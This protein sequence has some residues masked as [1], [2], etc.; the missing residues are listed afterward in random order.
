MRRHLRFASTLEVHRSLPYGI[1]AIAVAVSA[2]CPRAVLAVQTPYN[3]TPAAVVANDGVLW[4]NQF[5]AAL[6]SDQT[7]YG[8][9]PKIIWVG[10]FC[11]SGG[12]VNNLLANPS[13]VYAAA[14]ANWDETSVSNPSDN[15]DIAP[16]GQT[17]MTSSITKTL[18]NSFTDGSA[19]VNAFQT[20]QQ[21]AVGNA[22]MGNLGYNNG[23]QAIIFSAGGGTNAQDQTSFWTDVSTAHNALTGNS[24]SPWPAN[25]IRTLWDQGET[26]PGA[27]NGNTGAGYVNGGSTIANLE[28]EITAAYANASF[29]SNNKLFIYMNDHG[30]NTDVVKSRVT[31]NGDGTYR[32]SY[33]VNVANYMPGGNDPYGVWQLAITTHNLT[34]ADI[35]RFNAGNLPGVWNL[36][37]IN[38]GNTI[39]VAASTPNANGEWLVGGTNYDFSYDSPD[40]PSEQ[41][42]S[43]YESDIGTGGGYIIS[44]SGYPNGSNF[45]SGGYVYDQ[46]AKGANDPGQWLG[47]DNGG[48]GWV[49]APLPVL[50]LIWDPAPGNNDVWDANTVNWDAGT[51]TTTYAD[52]TLVNFTDT[53]GGNYAVTLN[54][55]V[56]PGS[57][58]VNNSGGNYTISGTGGIVGTGAL[59]K[60]G[61]GS[62]TLNTI[63][64]YTGGTFVNAGTL[65]AGVQG[66]LPVG[67]V[68]ITGGSLELGM[69][70]GAATITSLA[71]SGNGTLDLTNNHLFINYGSGP[72]PISSIAGLLTVGRAGGAWNGPGGIVTSAPLVSGGNSYGL[73]YADA[74]DPGNPA[75]LLSGTIEIKYT[76]LGDANLD[77]SVNGI[78]FGVLAANFNKA[79]SRWDAGDFNYDN[80]VNGIDFGELAANFNKGASGA[81]EG[82]SALSDPAIVA[83]AQANGLMADVPEPAA[84]TLVAVASVFM[85]ARRRRKS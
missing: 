25:A 8:K 62:L 64:T 47:W 68:S 14:A 27:G 44:D 33:E 80:I 7:I 23:D 12:F 9:M 85:T 60:N 73:G 5:A 70:T 42:W 55:T 79:V 6:A 63:N 24:F 18:G 21:G 76:L 13:T 46:P 51:G 29:T 15:T 39:Q 2:A 43:T 4:D 49:E 38:G 78:D 1:A 30:E 67:P 36:N 32:Y 11:Y 16:F 35:L 28:A 77:S 37:L 74:A 81:S 61:T 20:P 19:A 48:D 56:S 57:V 31:K 83:F 59:T 22:A 50:A 65:V 17:F 53:N 66:A 84:S 3:D 72:D 41:A 34:G 58:T 75:G 69:S 10:D 40:A 52:N 45:G 26:V 54:N 82:P 71:I